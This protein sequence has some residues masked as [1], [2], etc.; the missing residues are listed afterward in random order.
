MALERQLDRL[1]GER[2]DVLVVGGGVLGAMVAWD[3]SLRGLDVALVE[4]GDFASATSANSLKIVHGGLR[5]LQSLNLRRA[6][7][8]IRE[9]SAWLRI[10]PHL[11]EP[12]G[13]LVGARRDTL[14]RRPVLGVGSLLSDLLGWDRNRGIV[15]ERRLPGGR[16]LSREECVARAPELSSRDLVGGLLFH[17]AQMYSSERLVLE[18]ILAAS[19]RGAV[20]VN[21]AR[22]VGGLRQGGGLVGGRVLDVLGTEELEVRAR[23]VV[24]AAGAASDAV[25]RM[26]TGRAVRTVAGRTLAV[27]LMLEGRG[28]EVAFGLPTAG[29]DGAER[30]LFFVP[31]RGR[32]LVG[33]G[34]FPWKGGAPET[35][36]RSRL[37]PYVRR[38]REQV[39]AAWPHGPVSEGD[40]LAVHA[41]L[42][43]A[44]PRRRPDARPAAG[45][46]R[47]RRVVDHEADGTPN[48]FTG[49]SVKYTTARLLAEE[50][51][52][53]LCDRLGMGDRASSTAETPLPGARG[54]APSRLR[55]RAVSELRGQLPVPVIEHLVR[56]Y[57]VRYDR[58]LDRSRWM[59]GWDHRVT[60]GAPVI[61]A[62]LAY[63]AQEEMGRRPGDLLDRRTELGAT[64]RRGSDSLRVAEA[65]LREVAGR[66]TPSAPDETGPPA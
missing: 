1:T 56:T 12:L 63:G 19:E 51:V 15:P 9:R 37:A 27:N 55:D 17:D 6:R 11:V 46:L 53:R 62:Q 64:G 42:L 18:A 45:L 20:V 7:E 3:A 23:T 60:P 4:Q 57:G 29:D 39:E 32:T 41:G 13:V 26:L 34:H 59:D 52:D 25:A 21:Y 47:G 2:H 43:P 48:A 30:L 28:H 66:R 22:L 38:F 36:D 35:V 33:T 44:R 54:A 8:S 10:A 31:W 61:R 24:N 49:I 14:R 16:I 58:V 5:Y 65:V 40:V 50:L